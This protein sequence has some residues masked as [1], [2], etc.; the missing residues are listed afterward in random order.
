MEQSV[1]HNRLQG[2]YM[3]NFERGLFF[4]EKALSLSKL[5]PPPRSLSRLLLTNPYV[6]LGLN[7]RLDVTH[8][9]VNPFASSRRT[10]C[11]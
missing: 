7:V 3:V 2:M 11:L 8:P 5:S 10:E 9:S 4:A 1:L 6:P